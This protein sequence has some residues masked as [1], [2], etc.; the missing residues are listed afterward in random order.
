M[1]TTAPLRI[2]ITLR[3]N[4]YPRALGIAAAT[5]P[6]DARALNARHPFHHRPQIPKQPPL[7]THKSITQKRW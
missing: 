6:A 7:E 2:V 1:C 3:C 4:V 5:L